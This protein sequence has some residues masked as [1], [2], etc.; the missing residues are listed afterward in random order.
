M[1]LEPYYI[2]TGVKHYQ[3]SL[4][5]QVLGLLGPWLIS[6]RSTNKP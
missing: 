5:S 2:A 4:S 3:L 1:P 6:M